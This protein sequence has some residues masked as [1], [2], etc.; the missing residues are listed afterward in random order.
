MLKRLINI[1]VQLS[2]WNMMFVEILGNDNS[3]TIENNRHPVTR[4]N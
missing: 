4:V 2:S 3:V 1:L